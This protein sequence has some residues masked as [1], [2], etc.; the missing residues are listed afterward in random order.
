[1]KLLTQEERNNLE[2]MKDSLDEIQFGPGLSDEYVHSQMRL[3]SH[4]A[5]KL[6]EK[7]KPENKENTDGNAS[8]GS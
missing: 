4:F 8:V 6:E 3:I 1:M 7:Y 5:K 2:W